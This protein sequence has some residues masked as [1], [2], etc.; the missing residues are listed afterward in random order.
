MCLKQRGK[1]V[2]EQYDGG[3]N[4]KRVKNKLPSASLFN[5]STSGSRKGICRKV[6]GKYFW[7]QS[8]EEPNQVG[9]V[10]SV[11]VVTGGE[12]GSWHL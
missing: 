12:Y 11:G 1:F 4:N 6:E 2:V 5:L 9:N 8:T 3:M 7:E 10:L